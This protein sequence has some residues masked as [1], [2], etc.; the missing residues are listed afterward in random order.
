MV[1]PK[2]ID[3]PNN[4]VFLSSNFIT[5]NNIPKLEYM[6]NMKK[7]SSGKE[8]K[9]ENLINSLNF[10]VQTRNKFITIMAMLFHTRNDQI[11]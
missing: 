10:F 11:F 7:N 8:S 1:I 2:V 9:L 5:I 4:R 6:T 3:N